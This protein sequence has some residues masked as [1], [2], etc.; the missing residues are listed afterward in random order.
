M[1]W[2]NV[3]LDFSAKNCL[4]KCQVEIEKNH[5]F[6]NVYLNVKHQHF[7]WDAWLESF[8][9]LKS[10][11]VMT[12]INN[13]MKELIYAIMCIY[14]NPSSTC[15]TWQ[16]QFLSW[17]NLELLIK[18][19]EISLPDVYTHNCKGKRWIHVFLK[20][21][22]PKWNTKPLSGIVNRSPIPFPWASALHKNAQSYAKSRKQM[23]T[24]ELHRVMY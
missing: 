12:E 18:A 7:L 24:K 11:P 13:E 4:I 14:P 1:N 20:G 16:G 6:F 3:L 10:Y 5:N 8:Y 9:K 19:E 21:I 17:F 2:M 15:K 22:S 23:F